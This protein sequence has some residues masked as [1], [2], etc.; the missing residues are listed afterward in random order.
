MRRFCPIAALAFVLSLVFAISASSVT[1]F[2]TG[3]TGGSPS[4][5]LLGV[6]VTSADV[7][8]AFDIDWSHALNGDT[9]AA[10]ATFQVLGFDSS[11]LTLGITITNTTTLSATLTNAD[12]LGVGFGVTPNATGSYVTKGS[13]FDLVGSGAGP[14]QNFPGG[15]KGI[16]VCL[17]GQVCAGGAVAQGLH[18]GATD[19]FSLSLSGNFSG[20]TADLLYFPIKFQTNLGSFEPGGTLI[21]EPSGALLFGAGLLLTGRVVRRR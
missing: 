15:Y 13:V 14:Q 17:Y 6:T 20:G 21:P 9:L 19:S 18:A 12:I 3:V 2:D 8:S 11:S 7:G 16:D 5:N 1:F 4:S 10:T